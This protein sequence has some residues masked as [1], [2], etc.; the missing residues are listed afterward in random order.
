[1][2][3][4][5]I[6]SA[7][8]CEWLFAFVRKSWRVVYIETVYVRLFHDKWVKMRWKNAALR[9]IFT[10]QMCAVLVL[11]DFDW[12][13]LQE[14]WVCP[15]FYGWMCCRWLKIPST[16]Q[17]IKHQVYRSLVSLF[18][19]GWEAGVVLLLAASL[20]EFDKW[21]G[22]SGC[23]LDRRWIKVIGFSAMRC[24]LES[25]NYRE[26]R[27]IEAYVCLVAVDSQ[28]ASIQWTLFMCFIQI[29]SNCAA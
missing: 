4:W 7:N 2:T 15:Q 27:V 19:A 6:F 11:F 16:A 8:L 20:S 3:K 29:Q 9:W 10:Q 17:K 26:W 12:V 21:G 23:H 1:M 24:S 18:W 14:K 5:T 25:G 22:V 13:N 28:W